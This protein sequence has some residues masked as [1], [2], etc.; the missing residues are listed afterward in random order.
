MATPLYEHARHQSLPQGT[1]H[2]GLWWE[3]FFNAYRDDDFGA[4]KENAARFVTDLAGQC[5]DAAQLEAARERIGSVVNVCGGRIAVYRLDCWHLVTGLGIEHPTENGFSWHRTL[6][7][8]YLPGSSVKG[9]VRGW[10]EWNGAEHTYYG[11]IEDWFGSPDK[12]PQTWPESYASRA[13][14]FIFFDS[15]PTGPVTLAADVMTPHMGQ[16]YENGGEIAARNGAPDPEVVPADWHSPNPIIFLV[17]KEA[18][19]Q[20]GVAIR[21]NLPA[22]ARQSAESELDDVMKVLSEALQW[23]GA[24]AK[25]AAGYGRMTQVKEALP[26]V[27]EKMIAEVKKANRIPDDKVDDVWRGQPLA[28]AWAALPEGEEKV[29][30]KA[31]I[32]A[33][34]K[35]KGWW[36][37]PQGA[38]KKAK[39]I[40]EG[41]AP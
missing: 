16:W 29:A 20:F 25:T 6:G 38:G 12:D 33:I 13:G 34:W 18:V 21:E 8:P 7:T 31:A 19:F 15:L 5:G 40:Y 28:K 27:L 24:G 36:E 37:S 11:R 23:A 14:W 2:S 9:L 1:F 26:A 39:A 4:P 17:V 30:V 10:I 35:E 3:R 32:M 22:E 41:T